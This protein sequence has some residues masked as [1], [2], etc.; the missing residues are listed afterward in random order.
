MQYIPKPK[1]KMAGGTFQL[2]SVLV[3]GVTARGVRMA[4]REVKKILIEKKGQKPQL[5]LFK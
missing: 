5:D 3:K 2:D 4:N 1:Q